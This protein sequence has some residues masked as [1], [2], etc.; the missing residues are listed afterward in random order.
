M[1]QG[2][3]IDTGLPH[4]VPAMTINKVCGSGLKAV[5]LAAQ[6]IRDGVIPPHLNTIAVPYLP[7][8]KSNGATV[9]S[10]VVHRISSVQ[11]YNRTTV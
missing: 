7:T 8:P 11:L 6:A 3:C 1:G 9:H 2:P 5:M 4:A 10:L